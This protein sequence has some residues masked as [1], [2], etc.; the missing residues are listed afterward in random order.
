MIPA[1][2][3][4]AIAD[5]IRAA[6]D[7]GDL[8]LAAET[9]TA[10]GTWRPPPHR[11]TLSPGTYATSL[12][13]TLAELTAVPA[14]VIAANLARRL[15]TLPWISAA[16]PTTGYLTITVTADHLARLPARIND[17]P[18]ETPSDLG[19]A[20]ATGELAA[21]AAYYGPGAVRFAQAAVPDQVKAK[22]FQQLSRTLDLSNPYLL[23]LHAHA[24]AASTLRWA[25]DLGFGGILPPAPA[26]RQ[27]GNWLQ[28]AELAFIEAMS[29][30][31]ERTAA[32]VRRQRPADVVAQLVTLAEAW[33]DCAENC[34]ALP[35]RGRRAP[36][37]PSGPQAAARLELAA[38]ARVTLSS[39]LA[40]LGVTA[41]PRI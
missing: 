27:A 3:G 24:D 17:A 8:P 5:A 34:P 36:A 37:D 20:D 18:P 32:A 29:W 15:A 16:T 12:P 11:T 22:I 31:P 10:E 1:D 7:D 21:A 26:A 38:A 2:L 28:P 9:V 25:A 33:L 40:L 14:D 19:I 30:L 35:F 13:F 4:A 6:V 23:V 41:P 39:G